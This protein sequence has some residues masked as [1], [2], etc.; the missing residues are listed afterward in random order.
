MDWPSHL[1]AMAKPPG[2]A[3][4]EA[5]PRE[6]PSDSG[7]SSPRTFVEAAERLLDDLRPCWSSPGTAAQWVRSIHVHARS[8]HHKA[9]QE[10]SVDDVAAALAPLWTSKPA[11]AAKVRKHWEHVFETG[12]AAGAGANP[13]AWTAQLRSRLQGSKPR[14]RVSD[15]YGDLPLVMQRLRSG[16]GPARLVLELSL[17]LCAPPEAVRRLA[18]SAVR[19]TAN[20]WTVATALTRRRAGRL[21]EAGW[22]V[23]PLDG[24]W[25]MRRSATGTPRRLP[26]AAGPPAEGWLF[27]VGDGEGP[28][29]SKALNA[30]ATRILGS[31]VCRLALPAQE[32]AFRAWAAA[33]YDG[34]AQGSN[35]LFSRGTVEAALAVRAGEGRPLTA[36]DFELTPKAWGLF[37]A[38]RGFLNSG[39]PR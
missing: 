10:V 20:G 6:R 35:A 21:E 17:A 8:F 38:W 39:E 22:R 4:L 9:L 11:L 29:S 36:A 1:G 31:Q 32:A 5:A 25:V 7:V 30:Q 14:V 27:A 37:E 12:A 18:W 19:D 3:A 24:A 23:A 2:G 33:R 28:L 16:R 34:D 15:A 13:A 26:S